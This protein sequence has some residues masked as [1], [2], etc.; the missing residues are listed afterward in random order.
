MFYLIN[1]SI[2]LV[3]NWGAEVSH[4]HLTAEL[5]HLVLVL[6]SLGV[7]HQ[8]I[9]LPHLAVTHAILQLWLRC[10]FTEATPFSCGAPTHLTGDG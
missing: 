5:L 2:P 6:I 3:C 4:T 7:A 1:P 10:K 8:A 9:V